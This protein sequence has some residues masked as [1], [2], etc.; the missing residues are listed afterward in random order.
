METGAGQV[1]LAQNSA[2][3]KY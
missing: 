1:E 3:R 2:K